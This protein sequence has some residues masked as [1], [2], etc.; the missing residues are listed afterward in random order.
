MNRA[1]LV[2]VVLAGC[3]SETVSGSSAALI[4]GPTACA[5]CDPSCVENHDE[6]EDSELTPERSEDVEYNVGTG[7]IRITTE[8]VPPT[9]PLADSD[10]DGVPDVADDCVG[11]GA[12]LAADGSC[13]GDT[14]FYHSLAYGGPAEIDPL[15]LPIQVRTA[16]VY[17]LMDT[18]GSMGGEIN[19][20]RNDL[21]SGEFV[22]GCPG[23]IIGATRCTMPDAY[24]G[25]G[26]F[27]DY[28][29]APYGVPG[30]DEVFRHMH[31]MDADV[32]A[33]QAAVSALNLHNGYDLPESNSQA[34][35]ALT[36]GGGL[37]PYLSARSCPAGRWGYACFRD[38]TIPIIVHFT[39][40]PYHNG[41]SGAYPYTSVS[42]VPLPTAT[43]V[44]GNE[45]FGDAHA[46]GD[47]TSAFVGFSGNNCGMGNDIGGDRVCGGY[48]SY[49]GDATFSF[50]LTTRT[51]VEVTIDGS[52]ST[53]P[54]VTL[55]NSGGSSIECKGSWQGGRIVRF[56]DPGTY[57]VVVENY[58]S[59]CGNYRVSFGARAARPTGAGGAPVSWSDAVNAMVSEGVRVITVYSGGSTGQADANAL[60][61]ATG[62]VSGTGSRYVFPISSSGGGLSTAVVDAIV[63]LANYSRMDV[64]VRPTDDPSTAVDERDFV[65]AI[66][67]VGWG[68]GSCSGISGG[69][70]FIQCLPGTEVD[71]RVAFQNDFLPPTL[72][73]QVFDFYLEV[74][75]DGTYVLERVPVRIVVPPLEASFAPEGRYWRDHDST[76]RC[77]DNERPDWLELVWDA[78]SLPADTAIRWEL[79]WADSPEGLDSASAVSFI[80]PGETSPVDLRSKLLA[81]GERNF[82]SYLRATAVLIANPTRTASPTLTSMTVSYRCLPTE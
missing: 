53:Y 63:D 28:P 25:V 6:P 23:G 36:T 27:D 71:F 19:T 13:Y 54:A 33:A 21:T 74:V 57:Y 42:T 30:L 41:P 75:G 31:D 45:D 66:A 70:V 50:T 18:T 5:A 59:Y 78:P 43:A 4:T 80:A 29:S 38:G 65:S 56:L 9:P 77:H 1:A 73:A 15:E 26:R 2:M 34:L 79:R 52:T 58:S 35:W 22:T 39:D 14:F 72:T 64:E 44:S 11:P 10:G 47:L 69:R 61:D 67:A 7:G 51:E 76:V 40:A 48:R 46:A 60:A 68:A 3:A 17:F 49:S 16:D 12:F 20:L 37:G 24:F 62:S 81:A 32:G 8:G 82:H 55:R